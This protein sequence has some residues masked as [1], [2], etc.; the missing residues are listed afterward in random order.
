MEEMTRQRVPKK[1]DTGLRTR[2][3]YMIDRR[4]IRVRTQTQTPLSYST[5]SGVI[6]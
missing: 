5:Y 2:V 4:S 3:T 1:G 6:R